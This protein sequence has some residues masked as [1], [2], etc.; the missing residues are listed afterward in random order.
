MFVG[1]YIL[2]NCLILIRFTKQSS[3][4]DITRIKIFMYK[5]QSFHCISLLAL[6]LRKKGFNTISVV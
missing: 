6:A 4:A 1:Y 2:G 3:V 5:V